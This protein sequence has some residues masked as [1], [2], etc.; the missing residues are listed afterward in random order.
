HRVV[1]NG[2]PLEDRFDNVA[3]AASRGG[4]DPVL[5]G[6][7]DQGIDPST[8]MSV[9][10][11][12]LLT[13][14]GVLPGFTA[15][16]PLDGRQEGWVEHLV[17]LGYDVTSGY[18][19]LETESSRPAEH[20]V[21]SFLTSG[22]LE[23][24]E[25]SEAPWFA[26]ASY[27]RPHPP[28]SAAGEYST[29]YDNCP[30]EEPIP[31]GDDLHGLHQIALTIPGIAAPT[32]PAEMEALIRQYFGMVSEVDAQVGRI[33]DHLQEREV[34]DDT[35][36]IVTSDHGEQLGD[37]GLL[38]KLGFFEQSYRIPCIISDPTRT[39]LHGS[40]VGAFT[41]N[42]DIFP[43]ILDLLSAEPS[44]QCD[45][46]SLVPFLE[47]VTPSSWRTAAH[48]EWDW[49]YLLLGDHRVGGPIDG[50]LEQCNLV[51]HRTSSHA[52]VV[53]GDGETLLFDVKADPT[54]R[55]TVNDPVVE[56]KFARELLQWR[57]NHLGGSYTHMLLSPE[58]EGRWPALLE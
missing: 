34:L 37:H 19:A 15:V 28:Y 54:W 49:R 40:T 3:K 9:D 31:V 33:L 46:R 5:F 29:M 11:P 22:L 13:Y 17:D 1:A 52:Y 16:L 35:V 4:Y 12:R 55:T 43:T 36:I 7:T 58:R 27:I 18:Q 57:S 42:V 47:G 23:W 8:V 53:F 30:V 26:H 38:E 25:G 56:L 44:V 32:D 50:R 21:S 45:G 6:Y 14:E 2:T 20:S 10:D 24:I 41:E 39:D 48:Y 51:V